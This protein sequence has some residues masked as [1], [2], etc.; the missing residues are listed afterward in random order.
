MSFIRNSFAFAVLSFLFF[1]SGLIPAKATTDDTIGLL[2]GPKAGTY[3]IFGRDIANVAQK[4]GVVVDPRPSEGSIDNIKRL[5]SKENATIAIVQADVLGFLGRS[6]NPKTMRM[7]KNLRMVFPFYNEEIHVLAR[8]G[9]KDFSDLQGKTV[10]IGDDGSGNMLTAVNLFA[11]TG[12]NPA[13]TIKMPSAQGIVAVL[14]GEVDAAIY[15]GGKPVRLFKNLEDLSKPENKEYAPMLEKVHFVPMN[16]PKMLAEY[17]PAKI[18]HDDYNFVKGEVPTISV[19]AIMI[20]Y[21]F[22][23]GANP[24]R[25]EQLANLANSIRASIASL[26]ETGHPKWKEVDLDADVNNWKKDACVWIGINN[27]K[28]KR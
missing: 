24:E 21:N 28:S 27:K 1:I 8:D 4:A 17:K 11:I 25:C 12:I 23:D 5:N 6:K 22:S 14:K 10:A 26:K 18:T 13:K 7:A 15:V 9:I 16:D 3:Y 19:P 20:S 2:T